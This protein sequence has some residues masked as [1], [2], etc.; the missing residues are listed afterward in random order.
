MIPPSAIASK[1]TPASISPDCGRA[2]TL[3]SIMI[4]VTP[5]LLSS[6]FTCTPVSMLGSVV[7]F[8][9]LAFD[10]F[11]VVGASG[12]SLDSTI[13][14]PPAIP[15]STRIVIITVMIFC[16]LVRPR[17]HCLGFRRFFLGAFLLL[18]S[19]SDISIFIGLGAAGSEASMASIG[20]SAGASGGSIGSGWGVGFLF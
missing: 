11:L 20:S 5:R 12:L 2:N 14:M 19:S 3:F 17:N 10:A 13:T 16:F 1:T 8:K 18:L 6:G 9:T 7:G 15:P 4:P